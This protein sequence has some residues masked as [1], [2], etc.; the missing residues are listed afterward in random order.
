MNKKKDIATAL[1]GALTA[2]ILWLTILSRE[3]L[4]DTPIMYKPFHVFVSLRESIRQGGIT[5]NFLGNI[6]IFMPVG[7]LLPLVSGRNR[8]YWI[9]GVGLCF[10]LS[11]EI[12]QLI[13]ARGCFDLDDIMLN[14]LG[15]AIGFGIY[16]AIVHNK[17]V[18]VGNI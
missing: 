13:T 14:T 17:T 4:I 12:I 15:T 5:G 1:L 7:F 18:D 8:W 3:K 6:L 11:I 9:V 10:S 2:L 16:R